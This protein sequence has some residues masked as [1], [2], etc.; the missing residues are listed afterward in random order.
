MVELVLVNYDF[1]TNDFSNLSKEYFLN[2]NLIYSIGFIILVYKS[3]L[4]YFE[5]S[6]LVAFQD[7][8]SVILILITMFA[9]LSN[10][11][12]FGIKYFGILI[13]IFYMVNICV[14][15]TWIQNYLF[16]IGVLVFIVLR[17]K[18]NL[19]IDSTKCFKIIFKNR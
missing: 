7:I 6:A 10:K 1:M 15:L 4:S 11:H 18:V 3:N 5:S 13:E 19:I 14:Y 2:E 17:I 8:Y 16:S 9:D 12:L